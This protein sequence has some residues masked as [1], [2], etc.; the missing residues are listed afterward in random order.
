MPIL[1]E[2]AFVHLVGDLVKVTQVVWTDGR[3]DKTPVKKYFQCAGQ[4]RKHDL[5]TAVVLGGQDVD[6][7][8]VT[9][10][11]LPKC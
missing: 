9:D 2:V 7:T 1:E 4:A 3:F 5:D 6:Y 8:P 11:K 10:P